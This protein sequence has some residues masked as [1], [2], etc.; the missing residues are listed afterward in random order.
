MIVRMSKLAPFAL[1]LCCILT[2][3]CTEDPNVR[4]PDWE[5]NFDN[6]NKAT[7]AGE[8]ERAIAIGDAFLKKHP[9]NVD[10]HLMVAAARQAAGDAA[11]DASRP[12][13]FEK[14]VTHYERTLE[15]SKNTL[16]RAVAI[17]SLVQLYGRQALNKPDEAMRY[18]RMFIT[19]SPA[20]ASSYTTPIFLLKEARKYD[21]ALAMLAQMKAAVEPTAEAVARYAG[22]LHDLVVLAPDFPVETARRVLA[23]AVPYVEQAL[24]KY[25]RTDKTLRAKGY[26]LKAQATIEADPVRQRALMA[27]SDR[28]FDE[29]ERLM[30]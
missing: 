19:E 29:M 2:S 30:K 13:H 15:L 8:H 18:A 12:A 6:A 26:L 17:S 9:N 28:T 27:E 5:E 25:G 11:S 1:L 10:G 24:S 23:E 4:T 7:R 20:D 3:A 22:Q 14:A 16:F 21:E